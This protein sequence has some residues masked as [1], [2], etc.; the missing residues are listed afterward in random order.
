MDTHALAQCPASAAEAERSCSRYRQ[1]PLAQCVL[2][3]AR[4]VFF[5]RGPCATWSIL[6]EVNHQLESRM[7]E[8]RPSGSEGGG[9]TRS[10]YPYN[11]RQSRSD[12]GGFYSASLLQHLLQW[13]DVDANLL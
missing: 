9:T 6:S 1:C 10:P 2:C 4:A 3:G 7:R 12:D 8:N 11:R 5:V 13:P